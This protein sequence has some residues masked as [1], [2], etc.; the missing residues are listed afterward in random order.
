M[1]TGIGQYDTPDSALIGADPPAN[2]LEIMLAASQQP[3]DIGGGII[4][5]AETLNRTIQAPT[6]RLNVGY[7][8]IVRLVGDHPHPSG[9]RW[10]RIELGNSANGMSVT[11]DRRAV[12]PFTASV[13]CTP[14]DRFLSFTPFRK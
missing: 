1:T 2:V 7:A 6:L 5:N 3:V 11:R 4:A 9:F 8:V 12:S 10:H 14:A 13:A